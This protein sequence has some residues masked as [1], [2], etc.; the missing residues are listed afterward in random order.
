G[1]D[2]SG[3]GNDFA[4]FLLGAPS[5]F[6]QSSILQL[7]SR[8]RYYAVFA[9]DAFKIRPNLTL[10]YGVRWEVNQPWYD[11]QGKIEQFVPGRPSRVFPGASSGWRFPGAPGT[12][13]AL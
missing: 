8:T 3:T 12:R 1:L 9:H 4:D 11:T 6:E 10:N 7:D 2:G 13:R 5:Y